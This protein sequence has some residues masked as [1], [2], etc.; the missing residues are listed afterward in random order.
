MAGYGLPFVLGAVW[1]GSSLVCWGVRAAWNKY[2]KGSKGDEGG[3]PGCDSAAVS[4]SGRDTDRILLDCLL[5]LRR[6]TLRDS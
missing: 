2:W 4:V 5:K 6:R 3:S 1:G